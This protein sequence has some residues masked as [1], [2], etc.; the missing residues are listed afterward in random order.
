MDAQKSV[1]DSKVHLTK[2]SKP[3][4]LNATNMLLDDI[5]SI[6]SMPEID[7]NVETV[8]NQIVSV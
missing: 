5:Q 3:N 4:T 8:T 6:Q 7:L 1:L 2:K